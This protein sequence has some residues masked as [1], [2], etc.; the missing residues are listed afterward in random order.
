MKSAKELSPVQIMRL[1]R[2]GRPELYGGG[3]DEEFSELVKLAKDEERAKKKS[4]KKKTAKRATT[5]KAKP[6]KTAKK[7]GARAK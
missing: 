7:K 6:K 5:T 2:K 4:E 3:T 1:L